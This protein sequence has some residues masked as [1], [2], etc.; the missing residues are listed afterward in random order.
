MQGNINYQKVFRHL[1]FH[2]F[3]D[4]HGLRAPEESLNWKTQYTCFQ[5]HTRWT[6]QDLTTCLYFSNTSKTQKLIL[7]YTENN[8]Y[9]NSWTKFLLNNRQP[10]KYS[11]FNRQPST[12]NRQSYQAIETLTRDFNAKSRNKQVKCP[13]NFI[14]KKA[15][16]RDDVLKQL[17]IGPVKKS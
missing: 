1:K 6:L 9:L 3:S 12:V 17:R 16:A 5:K 2:Y 14:S 4:P 11:K 7:I 15:R 10:S 13:Y 8:T